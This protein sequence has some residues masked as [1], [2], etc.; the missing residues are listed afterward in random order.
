MSEMMSYIHA[1]YVFNFL[2][3]WDENVYLEYGKYAPLTV[4]LRQA[5]FDRLTYLLSFHKQL[6]N[7]ATVGSDFVVGGR[8][9]K[10]CLHTTNAAYAA[11]QHAP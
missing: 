2:K 1:M 8:S 6:P 11:S 9:F 7:V 5:L 3:R 4:E 10:V